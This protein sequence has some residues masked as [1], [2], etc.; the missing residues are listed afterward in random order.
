[1]IEYRQ[2]VKAYDLAKPKSQRLRWNLLWTVLLV[3]V[4]A[5]PCWVTFVAGCPTSLGMTSVLMV[6]LDV[7]L[8]I[9]TVFAWLSLVKVCKMYNETDPELRHLPDIKLD[10]EGKF[11]KTTRG[12]AHRLSVMHNKE[13]SLT[14]FVVM[15]GYKEP[16]ALMCKT[17]DTLAAQTLANKTIMVIGVEQRSS[18]YAE[19]IK[20]FKHRYGNCFLRLIQTVHPYALAGEIPGT[21]SNMNW[22]VRQSTA[23]MRD[24]GSPLDPELTILTKLDTDTLFLPTFLET[25]EREFLALDKAQRLNTVFQSVLTYNLALDQ[26]YFYTR[27][28]GILRTFL[29]TGLLIPLNINPMSVYSISLSL[30][31]RSGYWRPHYQMEDMNVVLNL[32]VGISKSVHICGVPL[33]TVCGPTSGGSLLEELS[34]WRAQVRRWTIGASEIFHLFVVKML[35]RHFR[36]CVGLRYGVIFTLYHCVLLASLGPFFVFSTVAD[37]ICAC[38]DDL[39]SWQDEDRVG[40]AFI[41]PRKLFLGLTCTKY[42]FVFGTVF[43]ADVVHR[44]CTGVLEPSLGMRGGI[45]GV[46]RSFL[47]FA[48][49]LPVLLAY[50]TVATLAIV[51]LSFRGREVCTHTPAQKTALVS[52]QRC[53]ANINTTE[54]KQETTSESVDEDAVSSVD[55]TPFKLVD[56]D[57]G[58]ASDL[59]L[60]SYRIVDLDVTSYRFL[61]I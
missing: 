27:V 11:V 10:S 26:R 9:A 8:W 40:C 12:A 29:M 52:S 20:F 22:A 59:D 19:K 5:A 30:A 38:P 39:S 21:A 7:P 41:S 2:S 3:G 1:M 32:M 35:R 23:I 45:A 46:A 61:D 16:L 34:E 6:A 50:S 43:F 15:V 13:P 58:L 47:H 4:G 36:S 53:H 42:V 51:E 25:L 57:L 14:H 60:A 49:S 33:P 54:E 24:E 18:D 56:M 55:S 31:R 17:L 44:R 37:F 28:T 48:S